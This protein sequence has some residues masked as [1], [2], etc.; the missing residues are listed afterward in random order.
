MN[1]KNDNQEKNKD[2]K[3]SILLKCILIFIYPFKPI[4]FPKVPM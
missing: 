3:K 1:K 2:L 4:G